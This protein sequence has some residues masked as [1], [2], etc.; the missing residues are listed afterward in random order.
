MIVEY[1]GRGSLYQIIHAFPNPDPCAAWA[2]R[3]DMA[4]QASKAVAFLHAQ[5][6]PY[7]HCDI[8]SPNYLVTQVRCLFF[9]SFLSHSFLPLLFLPTPPCVCPGPRLVDVAPLQWRRVRRC[10]QKN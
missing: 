7:V 10:K 4:T 5:D 9:L 3:L 2:R 1:C 6:P 8:K